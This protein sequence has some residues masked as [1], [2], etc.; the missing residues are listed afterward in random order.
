VTAAAPTGLAPAIVSGLRDAGVQRIFGM[1][2]GGPNLDLIGAAQAE[3][4]DFVLAHGETAACIMASTF[5]RL[6][7]TPGVA[8]VTRGPGVS[9]AANGLAQA[10]LDR[11]P[12]LL[13]A[14]TV[15]QADRGRVAHQR[16]DQVAAAG[17][18]T[19][20]SGV[21]GTADPARVV[22]DAAR[23]A[24][25]APEGAV[26]LVVD[27]TVPGDRP[28]PL[29][30]PPRAAP[31]ALAEARRLL[32][33]ARRPVVLVGLDARRHSAVLRA[34]LESLDCP[35]LVSYEA[36]GVVPESWPTY[37]GLF[38]GAAIERTV[39]D[40]ADAVL[41][42]GLDPVEPMPGRWPYRVPVVLFGSHPLETGYFGDPVLVT[43]SYPDDLP[44]LVD[45]CHSEW[46]P[47]AGRSAH[48][49]A[50]AAVEGDRPGGG[51][52][53]LRPQ[54][55]V[56]VARDHL[57]GA[58]VTVDAGAHMLV[59]MP[60]WATDDADRVLISNGLATMGFALPAAIGAAFARP[61]EPVV[62]LVGDGGLGMV[63][64][65]LETLARF[66]LD[67][68]VLVF[69]DGVLSLIKLKQGA[70]QGGVPAVGYRP[71]DFAAVASAMGVPAAVASDP[72]G[73]RRRLCRAG[74]DAAGPQWPAR[75]PR[76]VDAR[77]DPSG[78]PDVLRVIRGEHLAGR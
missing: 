7:G 3:G 26:Q 63:L 44:D 12:L 27:P 67:V 36:K 57:G 41:A 5:G 49:G 68:T 59:A 42:I 30:P 34:T 56:L 10:T 14:D 6:T 73:L 48:R 72:A 13:L 54:D 66:R 29:D 9:S 38:T 37:A 39:L 11:F 22:G 46:E 17:P 71:V 16:L 18:L 51:A 40:Q 25:A 15:W 33:A 21:L 55:V 4:I 32:G 20:W 28:P 70:G 77:V 43:G 69:N 62:C 61:G 52:A 64:A 65:E 19:K 23:L 78:Y 60:L 45:A 74:P 47:G 53:L 35:V 50:L 58:V 8:V 76:L 2:G 31:E 75:G 1:P 24:L